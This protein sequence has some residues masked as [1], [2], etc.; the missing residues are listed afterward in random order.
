MFLNGLPDVRFY[1]FADINL[2]LI[3]A[4]GVLDSGWTAASEPWFWGGACQQ[5]GEIF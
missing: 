4:L 1:V 5:G 2:E 3:G